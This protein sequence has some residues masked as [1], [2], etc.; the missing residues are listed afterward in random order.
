MPDS[1]TN[2]IVP[3]SV[4]AMCVGNKDNQIPFAGGG[5]DFSRLPYRLG[6]EY[7]DPEAN[8]SEYLET[9]PFEGDSPRKPGIHLHW[10]LPN[11]LTGGIAQN[12]GHVDFPAVPNRWLVIR[13]VDGNNNRN[14]AW[15]IESDYL[16]K[17]LLDAAHSI[18]VPVTP[19]ESNPQPYRYMGRV[20][21]YDQWRVWQQTNGSNAAEYYEK[22]T[23][24]GPGDPIFASYYPNCTNIFG[25]YDSM[26]GSADSVSYRV[27]GWYS[28]SK[29]DPLFSSGEWKPED[30]KKEYQWN[31][32][33]NEKPSKTL[34]VGEISRINWNPNQ[35]Y[36]LQP[37]ENVQVAIGNTLI[38]VFSA[39]MAHQLSD[40][41]PDERR[42]KE[43]IFDALQ[44][45][46]LPEFD[47]LGGLQKLEYQLQQ[48]SFGAIQGGHI[49]LVKKADGRDDAA[50]ELPVELSDLKLAWEH[51][52]ETLAEVLLIQ[53]KLRHET[54]FEQVFQQVEQTY[55]SLQGELL[56][57]EL[58][59]IITN[60][61][62]FSISF[63]ESIQQNLQ[64]QIWQPVFVQ[65]L[66]YKQPLER[67]WEQLGGEP[68]KLEQLWTELIEERN[69]LEQQ[70][71]QLFL[72]LVEELNQLRQQLEQQWTQ[73]IEQPNQLKQ[74]V[75]QWFAS[76]KSRLNQFKQQLEQQL[77]QLTDSFNQLRQSLYDVQW[78]KIAFE[79]NELNILQQQYDRQ[80]DEIQD[81][82]W[83]IFADWYKYMVAEYAPESNHLEN[84]TIDDITS[85]IRREIDLLN[86][87]VAET[88][89]LTFLNNP[90]TNSDSR[91]A[92]VNQENQQVLVDAQIDLSQLPQ[93]NTLAG[94]VVEKLLDLHKR[95]LK[96]P[97]V[98]K[99]DSN[100]T[101]FVLRVGLAS[102]YWLPNE[103]V[104]LLSGD[105]SFLNSSNRYGQKDSLECQLTSTSYFNASGVIDKEGINGDSNL[106]A[107]LPDFGKN[108]GQGKNP[109]IPLLLQWEVE[110]RPVRKMTDYD[111]YRHDTV[112]AAYN[113]DEDYLD[114]TYKSEISPRGR[115]AYSGSTILT[116]HASLNLKQ[117][118]KTYLEHNS[119]HEGD[120]LSEQDKADNQLL[121]QL[122]TLAQQLPEV[123]V[124][125]QA[126]GGFN[127]AMIMRKQTLRLPVG[128]PIAATPGLDEFSNQRVKD[129]V[130]RFN[131]HAPMPNNYYN[132][133]RGGFMAVSQL[134][135]IDA[136][137]QIQNLNAD[138]IIRTESMISPGKTDQEKENIFLAPRFSQ[139]TRL[140]LLWLSAEHDDEVEMNSHPASSP[141]CGWILPNYLDDSLL[142]YDN[143]G[144]Y[145]GYIILSED[146]QREIW[147]SAPG[148]EEKDIR[149]AFAHTN[150]HLRDF[151]VYVYNDGIAR[152]FL[153]A[154]LQVSDV[155]L[156]NINP[157]NHSQHQQMAVLMGRPLA[158]VRASLKMELKGLPAANQ[159]WESFASDVYSDNLERRDTKD[160]IK[161]KVPVRLGDTLNINDGLVG[162]FRDDAPGYQTNYQ[163][164]YAPTAQENTGD[165]LHPREHTLELDAD[166]NSPPLC[167]TMIIDPR[168]KVHATT[169]MLPVQGLEI[170]PDQYEK[171]L[172]AM[173]VSFLGGPIL[174]YPDQVAFPVPTENNGE[175]TWVQ[176][177]DPH[178]WKLPQKIGNVDDR[179]KL[180]PDR[181]AI[182]EG[183]LEL[184]NS[185]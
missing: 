97:I 21:H 80:W 139:P 75:E 13:I 172:K 150:S 28:E 77:A 114:L 105:Q 163:F 37:Q 123:P 94:Q 1:S 87:K 108:Q 24:I 62:G 50:K 156:D 113:N 137:G 112:S 92:T 23:A 52:W 91:S 88:G 25:L 119:K 141:I 122:Q 164:F 128:D 184:R 99:S 177:Q 173:E 183:W 20:F 8:I 54:I 84:V 86:K 185:Q 27:V 146:K 69:Q 169:A 66:E 15:V 74:E 31:F 180:S 131:T 135:L 9:Q 101:S 111:G 98:E 43:F 103:P 107:N 117:A 159:S 95:L 16:S 56:Q 41:N 127:S 51:L 73:L 7:V 29:N 104:I 110:Y 147:H 165:I 78:E 109:W 19:R 53:T 83:Q 90:Q 162:Y 63:I 3:I 85:F 129:A 4:E 175:W 76:L 126:L 153:D 36:A 40:L 68:S 2:L 35:S 57:S 181:L 17:T 176:K 45:G 178:T 18:T 148:R 161:V 47:R 143:K 120:N 140:Q 64:Q 100:S 142:F 48:N 151:A 160:F 71:E 61:R 70:G 65:Q 134:R 132:P 158:L 44:T 58:E 170:P 12:D 157:Q 166:P 116:A 133:I 34:F 49:W 144:Q 10:A 121:D 118:I 67:L 82:R 124:L 72:Q 32:L 14:K 106:F 22:L 102:R 55:V 154:F 168:A 149:T 26:D 93:E 59:L 89:E 115:E 171:A 145:I 152:G 155:A 11:A 182:I 38:Q 130:D 79:L 30:F 179:A 46:L 6:D 167:V 125:T 60:T 136:F 42:K 39:F 174:S 5:A 96:L 81:S 33:G 138:N